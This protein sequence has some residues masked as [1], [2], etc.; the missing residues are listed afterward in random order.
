MNQIDQNNPKGSDQLVGD[1]LLNTSGHASFD[2]ISPSEH[3]K[4]TFTTSLDHDFLSATNMHQVVVRERLEQFHAI[5]EHTLYLGEQLNLLP[6]QDRTLYRSISELSGTQNE[7]FRQLPEEV[8]QRLSLIK[9]H[10]IKELIQYGPE[11]NLLISIVCQVG[12]EKLTRLDTKPIDE[13]HRTAMHEEFLIKSQIIFYSMIDS[14]I[15][16]Y[17]Y[18]QES[19]RNDK[20]YGALIDKL[21]IL[22]SDIQSI[23]N[24][25]TKAKVLATKMGELLQTRVSVAL[26]IK[27]GLISDLHGLAIESIWDPEA[28]TS[29]TEALGN[30]LRF[31]D[32]SLSEIF[33]EDSQA[34]ERINYEKELFSMR[35]YTLIYYQLC[36]DTALRKVQL[37]F[38]KS[39]LKQV[40]TGNTI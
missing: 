37:E 4:K 26:A 39:A 9:E 21:E 5:L 3:F 23:P 34:S 35:N 30:R 38:D 19:N 40:D 28:R 7:F 10:G 1:S 15:K 29:E 20:D 16:E 25:N 18:Y 2:L 31:I 22:C 27:I 33:P 14:K 8:L 13:S 6:E 17:K 32:Q 36:Q 24:R 12:E 11:E